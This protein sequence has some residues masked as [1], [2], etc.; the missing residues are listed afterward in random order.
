MRNL[1]FIGSHEMVNEERACVLGIKIVEVSFIFFFFFFCF[2]T[3]NCVLYFE[4]TL[5]R[6]KLARICVCMGA[7]VRMNRR[8]VR[9]IK[10]KNK[11]KARRRTKREMSYVGLRG[12]SVHP[13]A[14]R[15]TINSYFNGAPLDNVSLDRHARNNINIRLRLYS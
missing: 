12:S 1:R 6:A 13:S 8:H 9:A 11:T 4:C 15:E 14:S 5:T 10:I 3:Y 7:R 2:F